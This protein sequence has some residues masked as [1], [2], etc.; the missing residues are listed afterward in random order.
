MEDARKTIVHGD[1]CLEEKQ[2]SCYRNKSGKENL[3][4]ESAELSV[5]APHPDCVL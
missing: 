1:L 3:V 2:S 5:G 4:A